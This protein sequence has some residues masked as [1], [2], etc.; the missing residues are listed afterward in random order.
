MSFFRVQWKLTEYHIWVGRSELRWL[1]FN[2]NKSD[3]HWGFLL[4]EHITD[5]SVSGVRRA[6]L[7]SVGLRW[8]DVCV[9][10]EDS[11]GM[12]AC[13]MQSEEREKKGKEAAPTS[14]HH[15]PTFALLFSSAKARA[16]QYNY[17]WLEWWMRQKFCSVLLNRQYTRS[18]W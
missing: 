6:L 8:A 13:G 14:Y 1:K 2:P 16:E 12:R 9:G 4:E 3:F 5:N 11:A 15:T 17:F 10:R 18:S 7:S